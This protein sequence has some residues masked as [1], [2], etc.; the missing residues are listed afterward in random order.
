MFSIFKLRT[1]IIAAVVGTSVIAYTGQN[2]DQP[3]A[4]RAEEIDLDTIQGSSLAP[5][6]SL[7]PVPRP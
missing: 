4:L 6:T 3:Y 5:K 1:G 2:S 7:L